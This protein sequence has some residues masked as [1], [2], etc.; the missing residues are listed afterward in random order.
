MF[1]RWQ[2]W[3]YQTKTTRKKTQFSVKLSKMIRIIHII[4]LV[5]LV[6]RF[7]SRLSAGLT[8]LLFDNLPSQQIRCT[9]LRMRITCNRDFAGEHVGLRPRHPSSVSLCKNFYVCLCRNIFQ[10]PEWVGRITAVQLFFTSFYP[11]WQ[12]MHGQ[13]GYGKKKREMDG[14][15]MRERMESESKWMDWRVDRRSLCESD[16]SSL[17]NPW[18]V[19]QW[20]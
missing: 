5:S 8:P 2:C 6:L 16:R 7:S 12:H 10:P 15:E 3:I 13:C 20:M 17:T 9:E 14:E 19:K 11:K 4:K 1:T 18:A